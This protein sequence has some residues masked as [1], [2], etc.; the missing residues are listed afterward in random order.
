M[1]NYNRNTTQYRSRDFK[2]QFNY[3]LKA[4]WN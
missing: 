3:I 1:K 2:D 4:H